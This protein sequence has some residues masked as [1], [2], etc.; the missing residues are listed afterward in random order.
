MPSSSDAGLPQFELNSFAS[1]DELVGTMTQLEEKDQEI[2]SFQIYVVS[3]MDEG[4]V[5]LNDFISTFPRRTA[6]SAFFNLLMCCHRGVLKAEQQNS[7][8][9]IFL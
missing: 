9:R 3:L 4:Q 2:R 5:Y 8:I 1:M 6:S 7:D